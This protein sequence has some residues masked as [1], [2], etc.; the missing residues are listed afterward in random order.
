MCM[1][2][3]CVGGLAKLVAL[4]FLV[5]WFECV[6]CFGTIFPLQPKMLRLKSCFVVCYLLQYELNQSSLCDQGV[7]VCLIVCVS[8]R[9]CDDYDLVKTYYAKM[10]FDKIF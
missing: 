7:C 10:I 1:W 2:G 4:L 3:V 9:L 5:I 6:K 8:V